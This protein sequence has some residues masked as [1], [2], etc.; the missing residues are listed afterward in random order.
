[1]NQV[2]VSI[3]DIW[4]EL[5][6]GSKKKKKNYSDPMCPEKRR[7]PVTVSG[8]YVVYMLSDADILEDW[9]AVKKVMLSMKTI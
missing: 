7:K 1:M 3:S 8:P 5:H 4:N 9:T 6:F 2:S